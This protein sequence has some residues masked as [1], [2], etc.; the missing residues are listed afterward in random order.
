MIAAT[1]VP[2]SV[3][4][5]GLVMLD[6]G[7]H[8]PPGDL[9]LPSSYP[10]PVRQWVVPGAAP[11]SVVCHAEA[12][13]ASPLRTGFEQAVRVLVAQG[14][15]AITTSCG[16]LVLLQAELQAVAYPAPLVSSS[17]LALPSLLAGLPQAGV[18]TIS[19]ERLGRDHLHAAGVPSDRLGDVWIQGMPERS[20]FVQAILGAGVT[21]D[22][23][24]AEQEVVA[25]ALALRARAPQ[26]RALVLECTNLPPY[27]AAL[28]YATG[29]PVLSLL[30]SRRLLRDLALHEPALTMLD[31]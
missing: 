14:C 28:R 21:L 18:L 13:R 27:A 2:A 8:R 31:F 3:A 6:T 15:T 29:W 16:F 5:L 22:P 17:L 30:H 20:H 9:G 19:A 10:C 11:A 24:L 7:F 1:G 12:L 23:L 26:L 25:A 4:A